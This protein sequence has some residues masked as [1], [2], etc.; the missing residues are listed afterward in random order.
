MN[1]PKN[2]LQRMGAQQMAKQKAAKA[3]PKAKPMNGSLSYSMKKG[4]K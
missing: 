1:K 2:A 3:S 4:K